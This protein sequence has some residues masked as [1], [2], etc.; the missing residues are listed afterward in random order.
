M[1]PRTAAATHTAATATRLIVA[2]TR[3]SPF[4][5]DSA[6]DGA[7][8][9]G[10]ALRLAE[11]TA[12]GMPVPPAFCIT[13]DLFDSYLADT[14]L[15]GKIQEMDP[16]AARDAI[17]RTDLPKPLA[18]E[19]TAAYRQLGVERVAVRSSA[20]KEDS[21]A[22]SFA[23]QHDTVLDVAGEEA[24]LEAVKTCWASLWSPRA[25]AY[26]AAD[27]SAAGSIAVV[28]QEMVQAEVSGVLFTADP[29]SPK[30]H[31]M[32]VEACHGL[33]EGLVSGRVSSDFFALDDRTMEPVEE[34]IRYKVTKC[35]PI[36][37]GRIGMI[38]V[39]GAARSAPCLSRAQLR[40]LAALAL[41]VRAHYGSE[42]DIEWSLRGGRLYL[43]QTRPITTRPPAAATARSP[44]LRPQPDAVQHGALWSRMDIGEI[45]V[46]QMTP[47]GLSFARHH[48][49]YVHGPCAA[50]VGV[51]DTGDYVGYMGYLNGHVYL[52]VSY[53]SYLLGQCLP[54]RDQRHFTARFVSEEVDLA[55]YKNPYGTF[56]GGMEDVKSTAFWI[57]H[58]ATELVRMKTR[59]KQLVA[60]R[61][62]EFDRARGIDLSRLTRRELHAELNRYLD[63]YHDMHVGYMPYYINAFG[64]YGLMTE[65]CAK[66]LGSAGE[67]LQNR[68]KTDMSNLR[69]V[70]S[71]REIWSVAQAARQRPNVLSIIRDSPLERIEA[72]LREDEDGSLFWDRH[73][74]PF[75]RAN[76]TRSQ[77][78][79]ELT[80]PRWIDDP[81]YL[82]QMIRRYAEDGMSIDEILKR[83]RGEAGQEDATAVLRTLPRAK[84]ATLEKIIALYA[85]CSELRETARMSM[86]TSLWLIR[87]V[88]YEVARRLVDEGVLY[89]ADEVAFLEFDDVRAYL[90]GG[91]PAS[92]LFERAA[93]DETRR[94]Y[95]HYKR[96]PEPPLSFIGECDPARRER[97]AGDGPRL[98][99]LGASPGRVTGRARII[100]DLVWQADEFQP[101]EILVTR[102]TD[103]SWTPLFAIAGGV[104]T[105]IGSMLSHSSIVSREFNVPSVVNTKHAT[106]RINTGDTITVDGDTGLVEILEA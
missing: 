80:H 87:N 11:M 63:H 41:R 89:N 68:I 13:T 72:A 29:V 70:A 34:R 65:L 94:V 43:L 10:K 5:D 106:Q 90:A 53:T 83:N 54:T 1:S 14:G 104:V 81:S 31:R 93:I 32:I 45:F 78:E 49:K 24:L 21:A 22:Q 23:G 39:D 67:N 58:T 18:D 85:N 105:D 48:Q 33:G 82:F 27:R 62:F 57:K 59:C 102:Y 4:P 97:P 100:E 50:S 88:V 103:A 79:M 52:N 46:G 20:R 51:R 47:L 56:P 3:E 71:A 7:L 55:G 76:G 77:Q 75:L 2:L 6:P 12:A 36:E 92:E 25:A 60:S 17:A 91:A 16:A 74:E 30:P 35:A 69:T 95:E 19:I 28:V 8:L 64:A 99:G 66:W 84:R 98:A 37:P 9:G 26:R 44:F 86:V 38:K 40:D 42:Q 101:G 73:M 96:L 61:L 15:A